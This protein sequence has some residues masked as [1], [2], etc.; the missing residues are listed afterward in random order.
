MD[1]LKAEKITCKVLFT[2]FFTNNS[3]NWCLTNTSC[4]LKS[5]FY[6]NKK[7]YT[8]LAKIFLQPQYEMYI[9]YKTNGLSFQD[10]VQLLKQ[11]E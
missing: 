8:W 7:I 3:Q 6:T 9:N 11:N 2:T 10:N 4:D 1:H 5:E